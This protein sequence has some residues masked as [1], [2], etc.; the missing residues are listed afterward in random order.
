MALYIQLST[1]NVLTKFLSVSSITGGNSVNTQQLT[2][3]VASLGTGGLTQ[4][5]SNLSTLAIFTSSLSSGTIQAGIMST[6]VLY[7]SSIVGVTT[8]GGLA[9]IPSTL[10]TF[11]IYTSSI[12]TST[13]TAQQINVSSLSTSVITA[14]SLF[15]SSGLIST[16]STNALNF[17]GGFGY[18]TMPDIF[19]NTV[20]TS[21]VT[22]SNL[23]V[24]VNATVSPIQFFGFGTY[25]NSVLAELSTGATTQELLMFRG[26]NATDRIRFQTTGSLVFE[27]GVSSRLWPTVPSNVTPAM[28]INTSSNVGIQTASP[29]ATLDVAGTGRF[30][31]ASTLALNISSINGT[32][33]SAGGGGGGGTTTQALTIS[34]GQLIVSSM[35][36][37]NILPSTMNMWV[38]TGSDVTATMKYSFDGL[39]W[40]NGT[41]G[42]ASYG[43]SIAWNGS[44]WVAAGLNGAQTGSIKYSLNGINWLDNASGGFSSGTGYG[45]AW[46][47][48][49]WVAVGV[50]STANN[51][52]QFSGDG[53]N[54]SNS[55]G[56]GFSVSGYAVAWNGIM[57]VAVGNDATSNATI[58]Y[59]FD[60]RVWTNTTGS[61]FN[62]GQ[63]I[64]VA[65]NG[66]MWVAGGS[67]STT[68]GNMK[69]SYNGINWFNNNNANLTGIGSIGWNGILWVCGGSA[70]PATQ[71]LN[72]S[73]DGINWTAGTNTFTGTTS[74]S[75]RQISWN[76]RIWVAV[77]KGGNTSGTPSIKYSGDGIN[78]SN[79]TSGAFN[80]P[81]G[82]WGLGVAF[83]ANLIPSYQQERF[84]ILSQNI[85]IF[86]RST[87]TIL[88]QQS[89]LLINNTLS[90]YTFSSVVGINCNVPTYTLDVNG[91][92]NA[93]TAVKSNGTNLT[94]DRR[95]KQFITSADLD[96]CYS[97]VK[98]LPLRRF[99][100]IDA[101]KVT[102][103]DGK[104]VGFIADEVEQYY[105]KAVN[106]FPTS[107]GG[108]STLKHLNYDQIMFANFGATKKLMTLVESQD[109]TIKG[110]AM[111]LDTLNNQYSFVF[112]TLE[113]LQG[114]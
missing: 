44:L 29:G 108:F 37:V 8:G 18:L 19:P 104:Q 20:F 69:Y 21:T 15:V 27:A 98:N 75:G 64:C 80:T 101:F 6:L 66:R 114:R 39:A 111:A 113:G 24:G 92:I 72:Y 68:P 65:W 109:S 84:E 1:Q 67:D 41:G 73:Y 78:W 107:V 30:Q 12:E 102:K 63:G 31:V 71:K 13:L 100:F 59:S 54:W 11:A 7:A 58:K 103:Y 91:T 62:G 25:S 74:E 96:I 52:I 32:V 17:A 10:S 70:L 53:S 38:A 89:S 49:V 34:T 35:N 47:G 33:Y 9:T 50:D 79:A 14:T 40:S 90:I 106:I 88:V 26:S 4:I 76:G 5:P 36:R 86:L 95:I 94:S 57:W 43:N 28:V 85:P 45:V 87:N 99:E 112:S 82:G 93:F 3:T 2:S 16:L 56:S 61:G 83:S 42:F 46:N 105:P 110:Q 55:S 77:G 97:N 81:A 51:T 23:L 60:G 22:T 48:R